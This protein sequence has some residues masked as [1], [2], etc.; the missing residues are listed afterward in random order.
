MDAVYDILTGKMSDGSSTDN[1]RPKDADGNDRN[2]DPVVREIDVMF[3]GAV[4]TIRKTT[5][6]KFVKDRQTGERVFKGN[7][8]SWEIDGF[9]YKKT[10]FQK[11]L[12]ER[13]DADESNFCLNAQVFIK[14]TEKSSADGRKILMKLSGYSADDFIEKNPDFKDVADMLKGHTADELKKV[15]TRNLKK[16]EAEIALAADSIKL[17]NS[18]ADE[19]VE[20]EDLERKGLEAELARFQKAYDDKTKKLSEIP[21]N[22]TDIPSL[23]KKQNDLLAKANEALMTQKNEKKQIASNIGIQMNEAKSEMQTMVRDFNALKATI[24]SLNEDLERYRQTYDKVL[25]AVYPEGQDICQTCGQA[26]P[27]E[28]IAESKAKWEEEQKHDL[29]E[30]SENIK[31]V[32][33]QIKSGQKSMT[34]IQDAY[35]TKKGTYMSLSDTLADVVAEAEKL[36]ELKTIDDVPEAKA[37]DAE[38]QKILDIEQSRDILNHDI[39]NL[40]DAIY[41][42]TKQIERIDFNAELKQMEAEADKKRLADQQSALKKAQEEYGKILSQIDRLKEFSLMSNKYLEDYINSFFTHFQFALFDSTLDGNIVETCRMMVDGVPYGNGLN[43]GDRILCEIDLV[44]GFQKM[45]GVNLPI[46]VDDSE[47]VDMDR[48]PKLDNQLIVL[49]RTDDKE[50]TVRGID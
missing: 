46:F 42:I 13:L 45:M 26:L 32:S 1:V 14:K 40:S 47:S 16:A 41:R 35:R 12:A 25:K 31:A 21:K 50:L 7:E 5:T 39:R 23:R 49:R 37:I 18:I 33:A 19:R 10:E 11:W 4:H 3:D 20:T 27:A 2:D 15:L 9:P 34:N 44:K 24:D 36:P 30:I 6:K 43:H 48:I 29:K 17:L 8:D 28:K 22:E 38:I